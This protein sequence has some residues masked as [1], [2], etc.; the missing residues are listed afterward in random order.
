[1]IFNFRKREL[2]I[3]MKEKEIQEAKKKLHSRID[4]D[5]RSVSRLNKVL[6]NGVTLQVY[7]ATG[8]R[9]G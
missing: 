8:G 3:E 7:K 9:N 2:V 5:I 1:M 4:R 6:A